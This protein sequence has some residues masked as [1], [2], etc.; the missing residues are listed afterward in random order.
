MNKHILKPE[1]QEFLYNNAKKSP[2]EIALKKSPFAEISSSELAEQVDSKQRLTS[3]L[4][5][6]IAT[7][8]IYFPPRQNAEQCSSELTAKYKASLF[9]GKKAI[10][11]TGG[12][13]VDVWA[14]SS[15]FETVHYCEMNEQLF[16]IVKHNFDALGKNVQCH[17]GDGIE[18]LKTAEDHYDLIYLD[19]AR[20]DEHNRKMVSF[21]DCVPNV[22]E[23]QD[24]FFTLSENVMIKAS[25]MMDISLALEELKFVKK[26]HVIALKNECKE[27]LFVMQKGFTNEPKIICTNLPEQNTFS[28]TRSEEQN[29]FVSYSEPQQYLYEPNSAV[30]KAG[31][32]NSIS[33]KLGLKKLHKHTH[34]YTSDELQQD[35]PGKIYQIKENIEYNKKKVAPF[36]PDK[37]ANIKS[38]NF[39]DSP[40]QAQK[41]LALKDG[42]QAF[43]FC[44]KT[45]DEK[46]SILICSQLPK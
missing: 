28:F 14:L 29:T 16:P 2:T 46:Y 39:I 6:W 1:V 32:F 15:N 24:I 18:T 30:L 45:V 21:A 37:K 22:V 9:S 42:G 35:F 17:F 26:I 33:E 8:N 43:L 3:K 40:Q 41:K 7:P 10:D 23:L 11:I 25:P 12:L 13:G 4:P 27:L 34:L 31:A 5:T 38:Y 20:R 36:L 19:P 44:V